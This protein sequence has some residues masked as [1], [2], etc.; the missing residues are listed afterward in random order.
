M[1]FLCRPQVWG[2]LWGLGGGDPL[3]ALPVN[4]SLLHALCL[5]E[6]APAGTDCIMSVCPNLC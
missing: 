2:R 1:H 5:C 3:A 4:R 6:L